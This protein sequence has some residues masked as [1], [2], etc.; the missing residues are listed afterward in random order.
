MSLVLTILG[1]LFAAA[2]LTG[3]VALAIMH[4]ARISDQRRFDKAELV[5]IVSFFVDILLL[6]A[7]ISFMIGTPQ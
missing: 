7:A 3:L 6:I 1:A 2:V 4:S 5:F